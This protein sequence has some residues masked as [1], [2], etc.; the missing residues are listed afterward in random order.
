MI[1]YLT[2]FFL[3][4]EMCWYFYNAKRNIEFWS[5]L[6]I[7]S[8]LLTM[9]ID[10]YVIYFAFFFVFFQHNCGTKKYFISPRHYFTW[11][12]TLCFHVFI[13][14]IKLVGA[15]NALQFSVSISQFYKAM[16][17]FFFGKLPSKYILKSEHLEFPTSFT[18]IWSK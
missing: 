16:F 5:N 18:N 11:K 10:V 13:S 15:H 4:E 14:D 17:T 9:H 7:C 12:F 2:R 3:N 1:A 6:A 8:C